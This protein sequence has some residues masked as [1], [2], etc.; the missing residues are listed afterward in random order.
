[1]KTRIL[2][3]FATL[4][5]GA[6]LTSFMFYNGSGMA[7]YSGAPGEA[8]CASCHSGGFAATKG[9]T[10]TSVPEFTDNGFYADSIYRISVIANAAAFTRYGFDC[11]ILSP[12]NTTAGTMTLA[13]TGVKFL[14]AAGRRHATHSTT[15]ISASGTATFEFS[16]VAPSEGD[17]TIYA[18][19]NA[20]N[21][22]NNT[23]GDCVI[24]PVSLALTSVPPPT[25]TTV[26]ES[27]IEND[28]NKIN[29]VS[30]YPQPASSSAR[31]DF[32]LNGSSAVTIALLSLK[33]E[34]IR[35]DFLNVLESGHHSERLDLSGIAGGVYL[36]RVSSN[37]EAVTRRLAVLQ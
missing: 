15:K 9:I 16:W 30:L 2:T 29:S 1:M 7:G 6:A 4:A 14:N 31:V 33:G 17:A 18:I 25:N 10:I 36:V 3:I 19:S 21:G 27:I 24:T 20:V 12:T 28:L 13:G 11:T 34:K 22:N 8:T 5:V 26:T 32:F 35:E 23:S 37:E